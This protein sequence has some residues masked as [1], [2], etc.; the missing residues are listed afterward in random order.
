[1]RRTLSHF[2]IVRRRRN[3]CSLA[4]PSSPSSVGRDMHGEHSIK[5]SENKKSRFTRR[6]Q[7]RIVY[8]PFVLVD[9]FLFFLLPRASQFPLDV[10][11]IHE[12]RRDE[13]LFHALR[14]SETS[15]DRPRQFVGKSAIRTEIKRTIF[16]FAGNLMAHYERRVIKYS[17]R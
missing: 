1:M 5:E 6:R 2:G 8:S 17:C 7:C 10:F 11:T 13:K 14:C 15:A 3:G 4:A 9:V 12:R 16:S